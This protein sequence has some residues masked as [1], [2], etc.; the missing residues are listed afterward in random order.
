MDKRCLIVTYYF[1]PLGGGGVQRITKLIK[2][3]GR[4]GWNFTVITADEGSS[5][6]PD[7]ESLLNDLPLNLSIIR[8]PNPTKTNLVITSKNKLFTKSTFWKR[9]LR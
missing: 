5:T 1:P 2:Y 7:D 8:V 6:L 9:W 4:T 3:A